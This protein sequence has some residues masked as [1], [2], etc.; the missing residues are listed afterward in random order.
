MS[1]SKKLLVHLLLILSGTAALV[2]QVIWVRVLQYSFGN[3]DL[4]VSTVLA[5]FMGGL[6]LGSFLGGKYAER[7]GRP[8]LVYG[9]LELI[10]A[11]YALGITPLLYHMDFVFGLVGVDAGVWSLTAVRFLAATVLL[12]VPTICM[13]ATLPVLTV[14]LVEIERT[15]EGVGMLYFVNTLG[16]V[17]GAA[18][19]GFVL[20]RFLGLDWTLYVA[21][22]FGGLVF[23]G[24]MVLDRT[25]PRLLEKKESDAKD[26][27]GAGS[28]GEEAAK[29]EAKAAALSARAG[30][31]VLPPRTGFILIM[32][33]AGMCGYISLVN[34]VVWTR[35]LGFLLDG[36]V[37]GFSA[38]LAS[39]LLGIA[40]GSLII[41]PFIDRSR[42]LWGLFAVVQLLA[43][44]G[45]VL[46]IMGIPMVPALA[47]AVIGG[48]TAVTGGFAWKVFIVFLIIF[49]PCLFFGAAFPIAVTIASHYRG[50]V[51]S[52]MGSV[53]AA[54]TVGCILGSISGGIVLL[55][56]TKDL[57]TILVMMVFLSLLLSLSAGSASTVLAVKRWT[58]GLVR[59]R[60]TMY[61][62]GLGLVVFPLAVLV[63]VGAAWPN[64]N[65]YRLVSTRY[66][67]EDYDRSLGFK[68]SRASKQVDKIVFKAQGRVTVV[69]V[70]RL[71]DGGLRLRNNGLNEAYHGTS[72]PRY[73]EVIFY[74]GVLPY[75]LHP[76]P[77]R[78]LQI[79]LGG[80]GTAECLTKTDLKK[81]TV[82]EL[83]KEVVTASRFIYKTFGVKHPYEDPR[84]TARVDDGRNALL[85]SARARPHY[86]DIIVSQPSHAW[87]SGVASL[88]T[89]EHFGIVRKNLRKGGI[90]CQW[91]NLFRMDE[92]GMKALMASFTAAFPSVHVFQV[93]TNSLLLL[94]GDKGFKM[95]P[96]IVLRHLKEKRL[97]A[98]AEM[99]SID[100]YHLFRRYLFGT[101]TARALAKGARANSDRYPIIEMRLPWVLHNDTVNI[102]KVIKREKLAWG[103]SPD[104]FVRSKGWKRF[105][106]GMAEDLIAE[107]DSDKWPLKRVQSFVDRTA[108]LVPRQGIM[109]QAR[110]AQLSGDSGRAE[111][112][113]QQAAKGGQ[114][115]ALFLLG[116]TYLTLER[117][118]E[119]AETCGRSYEKTKRADAR[120]CAAE[121]YFR[122]GRWEDTRA[123]LERMIAKKEHE[124][125]V[126]V[127]KWLGIV[128]YRQGRFVQ[129]KKRLT[130]YYRLDSG[131]DDAPYYLGL[132]AAAAGDHTKAREY[133][134]AA[135]T[136]AQSLADAASGMGKRY[137]KGDHQAAAVTRFR[138]TIRK[139]ANLPAA[140]KWMASALRRWG[141]YAELKKTLAMFGKQDPNGASS[142]RIAF[143]DSANLAERVGTVLY[144][145]HKELSKAP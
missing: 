38:L 62:R 21:V 53:Y 69:T 45:C 59:G 124:E 66:A 99:F 117:Y 2:Y 63:L 47:D 5:V 15:G 61:E 75:M 90:F 76:K 91:I 78:A 118:R 97:K 116:S 42:D 16:A 55:Q 140:Y 85:R 39:F 95:D 81:L 114:D 7:F 33:A 35:M 11:L 51:S 144:S 26:G 134:G 133:F 84:V 103:V 57:N 108:K 44:I 73:A 25:L 58:A 27:D 137:A 72:D 68:V 1:A 36:T 23:A 106:K 98:Q 105:L 46:T 136:N 92:V 142:F 115:D 71:S 113:Y 107:Y 130:E 111:R 102:K 48:G 110:L 50:V 128:D 29:V 88:Y 70:H 43:G 138:E 22:T 79:G 104:L 4:A 127:Q 135:V 141:R 56:L 14:P 19:A 80:G 93:D 89:T 129:A 30:L 83:E 109:L 24:A 131:D 32:F 34:E 86:Y 122:Q 3:T 13:G 96:A 82:V 9:A 10:I 20:V 28:E 12:L 87:L 121:A 17:V 132:L 119:A 101:K 37:Y 143:K 49:L 31:D 112:L 145:Y 125:V 54:N 94:G 65:I 40:L 67:V 64:V 18:L 74:L 77:E 120:L 52:S 6:A 139:Q 123:I 100:A 41:T 8:I 60:S 126:A